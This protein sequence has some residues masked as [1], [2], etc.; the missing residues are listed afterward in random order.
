MTLQDETRRVL[1]EMPY[2]LYIVG[3]RM[4]AGVNGMMADWVMQVSF[5]PRLLVVS[6]END[7]RSLRNVR[8]HGAF[9]VNLLSEDE[10]GMGLAKRVAQPHDGSK[11][12]GRES[13]AA[14][15]THNKLAGVEYGTTERGCPVLEAAMG[16][17][18]CEA[19][20]FVDVGDHTLVVGRVV[21]GRLLR[22]AEVLTSGYTGW[23]YSG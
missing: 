18:E 16:W 15:K 20:K 4:D 12:A 19:E 6:F 8:V 3:T 23:T 9:T 14:G 13:E 10:D 21:D 5:E 11:I 7:S 17:L 22:D 1:D 2:G